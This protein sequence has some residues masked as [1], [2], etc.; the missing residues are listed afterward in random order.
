[1]KVET[2]EET[3][4]EES[5]ETA[6]TSEILPTTTA[7][8]ETV[9][10]KVE[11]KRIPTFSLPSKTTQDLRIKK[12]NMARFIKLSRRPGTTSDIVL[13]RTENSQINTPILSVTSEKTESKVLNFLQST[14]TNKNLTKLQQLSVF[15]L[16]FRKII[17][18]QTLFLKLST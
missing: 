8:T 14:L 9:T 15:C 17:W 6:S 16:Y 4:E 13:K 5:T 1:M 18:P 7:A 3:D 10:K 12:F 11:D 2:S